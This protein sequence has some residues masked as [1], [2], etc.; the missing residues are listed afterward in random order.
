MKYESSSFIHS[1][2]VWVACNSVKNI[3]SSLLK[4]PQHSPQTQLVSTC[5]W[6]LRSALRR[7]LMLTSN[8]SKVTAQHWSDVLYMVYITCTLSLLEYHSRRARR[9]EYLVKLYNV[10]KIFNEKQPF[11]ISHI[12]LYLSSHFS[13]NIETFY[14][15]MGT[16]V[17]SYLTKTFAVNKSFKSHC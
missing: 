17:C 8:L 4:H 7:M 13:L 3:T 9:C 12:I 10:Y 1:V 2:C 15:F 5:S 11:R 16:L 14:I 6:S